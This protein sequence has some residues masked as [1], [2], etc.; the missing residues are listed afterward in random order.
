MTV[1]RTCAG[2][3]MNKSDCATRAA[4][5]ARL[6]GLGITSIK[7]RC[8][9]RRDQYSI[10]QAVWAST[11]N[12][13]PLSPYSDPDPKGE[14]PGVIIRNLGSRA[15]V[16][17]EPNARDRYDDEVQFQPLSGGR[18]FCKLPISRLK[19]RDAPP[20]AICPSCEM[21]ESLGHQE[22]LSCS[23]ALQRKAS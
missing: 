8:A 22:G 23:Y 10:G 11:E 1:Y 3:A 13:Q 12:G 2:C 21:P 16:F 9:D 7:W 14:F 5:K 19:P 15:L 4:L 18:G 20:Q 6:I 17:I